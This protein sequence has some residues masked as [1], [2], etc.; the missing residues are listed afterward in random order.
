MPRIKHQIQDEHLKEIKSLVEFTFGHK[1]LNINDCG[2][3]SNSIFEKVKSSVSTDTLRRIFGLIETKSQPSLFTL[4]ILSKYVG[5]DG[6]YDFINSI[7]LVGKNFY[8][9]QILDCTFNKIMPFEGLQAL[10]KTKPCSDYYSTLHQLILLAYQKKD[11]LFFEQIF[12][13][14]SGFEWTSD[15]KYEIYQTIQLL[16]KLVEENTWLQQIALE[17]Y[18]SL[19]Y[20]FDYFI[21]WYVADEQTYYL[22]LLEKYKKVNENEVQK[23]LFYH[24]II[25]FNAYKNKDHKKFIMHYKE[26]KRYSENY[27]PNNIIK[28]RILGMQ[29][30]Y[31]TTHH[32]VIAEKNLLQI[33]FEALFPDIGD[34]VTSM[35]FLFNHLFEA[36]AFSLM[37]R[38]SEKWVS[39]DTVFFSIWTRI[40][41][42]QLCV[43]MTYAYIQ[44]DKRE[45][46]INYYNQINTSL[47]EIYNSSRFDKLYNDI[48]L[49]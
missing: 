48:K 19:P 5:F 6:Y 47:F 27:M 23:Q 10:Q 34:R 17:N 36:K 32:N 30:L 24:C 31:E 33:D 45:I 3:L 37:V 7:A 22:E 11:R 20:F 13:N 44:L 43:Y 9:R 2:N 40:N 1:I 8:Y 26:I 12:I 25:G 38:L 18:I 42:N 15:F 35:F 16:G 14:Q 39:N 28:S 4:E 41:W 49:N 21:E 46:A 29:F